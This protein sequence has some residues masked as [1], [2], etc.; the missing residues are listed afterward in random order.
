[1]PFRVYVDTAVT[2]DH[3]IECQCSAENRVNTVHH[4]ASVPYLQVLCEEGA[5]LCFQ[6]MPAAHKPVSKGE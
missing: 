6:Q 2:H 5:Q 3:L 4:N 1:M